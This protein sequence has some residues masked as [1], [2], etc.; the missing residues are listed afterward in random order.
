MAPRATSAP[1]IVSSGR[2]SKSPE[3]VLKFRG[4]ARSSEIVG[5]WRE[6][7]G[8]AG[9]SDPKFGHNR[10]YHVRGHTSVPFGHPCISRKTDPPVYAERTVSCFFWAVNRTLMEQ[11]TT[12]IRVIGFI[13]SSY[14]VHGSRS[15]CHR[16]CLHAF[17]F[18][19]R[20]APPPRGHMH[21]IIRSL[22]RTRALRRV[23]A[24]G[25]Q[26]NRSGVVMVSG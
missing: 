17:R 24:C 16:G 3:F 14:S 20:V 21:P 25:R 9:I 26:S 8:L 1:K 2:R 18:P 12:A 22:T 19:L 5:G 13:P 11:G 7:A 4:C 15:R 10:T 23:G 6:V